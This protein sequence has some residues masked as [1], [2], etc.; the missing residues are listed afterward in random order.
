MNAGLYGHGPTDRGGPM[1]ETRMTADVVVV[2]ARCAGA[3][4]ALLLARSGLD[5]LLLDRAHL[6]RDTTS[7]H[8]LSR[9]GVVLLQRWGLLDAVLESGAPPVRSVTFC[10]NRPARP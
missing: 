8:A 4:T 5:V 7:T 6:P 1:R 10:D 9:G 2:G 3:A